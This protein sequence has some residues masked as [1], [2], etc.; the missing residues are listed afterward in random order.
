MSVEGLTHQDEDYKVRTFRCE[1]S[2]RLLRIT[3]PKIGVGM[4]VENILKFH[5]N[6]RDN[7]H[8]YLRRGK[9]FELTIRVIK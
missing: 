1:H 6:L 3:G 2:A 5:T 4:F 9:K 8:I 7:D